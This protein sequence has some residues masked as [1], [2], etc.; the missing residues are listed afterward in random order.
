M[1]AA[2]DN[3]PLG[4]IST[5]VEVMERLRVSRKTLYRLVALHLPGAARVGRDYRFEEADIMAIWRGMRSASCDYI[6]GN[7]PQA[8]RTGSS[9]ARTTKGKRSTSLQK[10]LTRKRPKLSA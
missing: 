7:E 4:T 2:N 5:T 9:G 10:R 6:C 1:K 8:N 3:V